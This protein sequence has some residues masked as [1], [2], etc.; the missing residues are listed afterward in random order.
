[1]IAGIDIF[2]RCSSWQSCAFK[3]RVESFVNEG[4]ETRFSIGKLF[5]PS[6]KGRGSI[7]TCIKI[8]SAKVAVWE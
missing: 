2:I 5:F 7:E 8:G 3:N 4:K 1:M 6:G